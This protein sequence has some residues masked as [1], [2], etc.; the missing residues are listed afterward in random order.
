MKPIMLKRDS[1]RD[2]MA[3]PTEMMATMLTSM[4]EDFSRPNRNERNNTATGV[5]AFSI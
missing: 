3:T 5:K 4:K 1:P 2:V